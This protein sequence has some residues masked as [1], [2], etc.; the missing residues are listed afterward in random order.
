MRYV[1]LKRRYTY[2]WPQ[3]VISQSPPRERQITALSSLS[4]PNIIVGQDAVSVEDIAPTWS[5][6]KRHTPCFKCWPTGGMIVSHLLSEPK[7]ES[8]RV[9]KK[10]A[11]L[12]LEFNLFHHLLATQFLLVV[13]FYHQPEMFIVMGFGRAMPATQCALK[14]ILSWRFKR[15]VLHVG[16]DLPRSIHCH[17]CMAML[18]HAAVL[19]TMK[20]IIYSAILTEHLA[21]SHPTLSPVRWSGI[22]GP[23]VAWGPPFNCM[24][25]FHWSCSGYWMWPCS[26]ANELFNLRKLKAF[27]V[28][29][30]NG[31]D[32]FAV[33]EW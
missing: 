30:H 29:G 8:T 10:S 20:R 16:N 19:R 1:H 11:N 32:R 6:D 12:F 18:R 24:R 7:R 3:C 9:W 14:D 31:S 27:L 28:M 25:F 5:F 4:F 15:K 23:W 2:N 21:V 13:F 22:R 17:R 26:V 33:P